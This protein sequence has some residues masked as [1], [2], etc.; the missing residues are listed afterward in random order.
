MSD[1][2]KVGKKPARDVATRWGNRPALSHSLTKGAGFV[3]LPSVLLEGMGTLNKYGLTPA[4]LVLIAQLMNFK[5][6]ARAPYPSYARLAERMGVSVPYAR[7]LAK[8]LEVKGLLRRNRRKGDT[9]SFDFSPLFDV[10][11]KAAERSQRERE[12]ADA[13]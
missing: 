3:A 5:W 7:K 12:G 6:D 10:L 8:S 9:N 4:E 1:D 11:D 2:H 13:E